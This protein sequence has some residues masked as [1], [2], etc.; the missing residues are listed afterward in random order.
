[1][2]ARAKLLRA[3]EISLPFHG[4]PIESF[5]NLPHS[6]PKHGLVSLTDTFTCSLALNHIFCCP[7]YCLSLLILLQS[8]F[9][10]PNL[11]PIQPKSDQIQQI[12]PHRE[13]IS[14]FSWDLPA[15]RSSST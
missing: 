1:M 6:Q 9:I 10:H 5:N 14:I 11:V 12:L 4:P 2:P 3:L 15:L 8:R 7:L 13:Y